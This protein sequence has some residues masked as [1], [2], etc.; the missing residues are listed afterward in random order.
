MIR[1]L[2]A[3]APERVAFGHIDLPAPTPTQV[4]VRSRWG[5]AKHGTEMALFKGYAGPRGAYDGDL[6]AC[7]TATA[8]RSATRAPWETCAWAR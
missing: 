3:T 7:S 6:C 8:R 5:A 1:Q 4:R 2:I